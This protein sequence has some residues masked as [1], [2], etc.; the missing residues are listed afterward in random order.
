MMDDVSSSVKG[1]YIHIK[2]I[3]SFIPGMNIVMV[4]YQKNATADYIFLIIN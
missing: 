4:K 1:F 3:F 2:L